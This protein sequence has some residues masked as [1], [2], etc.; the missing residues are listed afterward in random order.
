MLRDK[1][2]GA[3]Q[4]GPHRADL[5]I[6]YRGLA[7]DNVLSRGQQKLMMMALFMAQAKWLKQQIQKKS[8]LL[9]DDV[10]AELDNENILKLLDF[11]VEQQ[12]QV[13]ITAVDEKGLDFSTNIHELRRFCIKNGE[14]SRMS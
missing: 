6:T 1:Y 14:V 12:Q 9:I 5:V 4:V 7:V 3:T 8:I 11:L 10:I 13:L 2:L